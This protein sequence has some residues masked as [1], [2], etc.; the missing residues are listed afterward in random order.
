MKYAIFS[1]IHSNLEALQAFLKHSKEQGCEQYACL[2]D[3]VGYGPN[4]KECVELVKGLNC[5][6]VV[7]NHDRMSCQLRLSSLLSMNPLASRAVTWT[8]NQLSEDAIEWI[9]ELPLTQE[10]EH[11]TIVH[12]SLEDP[13]LW[14][15]IDNKYNALSSFERQEKQ[16]CFYGHTHLPLCFIQNR[17]E[18]KEFDDYLNNIDANY[19]KTISLEKDLKYIVNPGSIGQPRDNDNRLSYAIFDSS[20]NKIEI[21]RVVY[22][23]KTT[24]KKIIEAGLPERLAE[25]LAIGE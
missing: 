11:F 21:Q 1:D 22:D 8:H 16:L 19:Y 23:F 5:P 20:N 12:A 17:N 15:Y 9:E 13:L 4:P 7:G 25:R 14:V 18:E 2:G 10:L 3:I 6:I 24:Q